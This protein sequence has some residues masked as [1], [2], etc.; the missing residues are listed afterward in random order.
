VELEERK[1]RAEEEEQ[2]EY[3]GSYGTGNRGA[4]QIKG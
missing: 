3:M 1:K 2:Y 4:G